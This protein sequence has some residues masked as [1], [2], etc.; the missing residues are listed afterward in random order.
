[1]FEWVLNMHL[2][3]FHVTNSSLVLFCKKGIRKNFHRSSHSEVLCK[4]PDLKIFTKSLFWRL[5]QHVLSLI[6]DSDT[7]VFLW[8]MRNFQKQFF[9][10]TPAG[11]S[12]WLYF[13]LKFYVQLFSSRKNSSL[14]YVVRKFPQIFRG[15]Y[16][17]LWNS[18]KQLLPKLR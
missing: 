1:M 11:D 10:R 8:I 14:K 7:R 3:L 6:K 12:F 2:Q 18:F 5:F 9:R 13:L 4:Q 16:I 17:I 15:H